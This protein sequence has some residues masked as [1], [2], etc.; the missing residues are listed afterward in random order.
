VKLKLIPILALATLMVAVP[1]STALAQGAPAVSSGTQEKAGFDPKRD[2][3]K[4]IADAIKLAKKQNKRILLDVG[5]EWWGWCKKLASFFRTDKDAAKVLK[6]K[7]IVVKVNYSQ[8]NENKEVLSMYPKIPG[9]PHFFVLDKD[10]K[11][12]HSQG[13]GELETGDHHDHDKMMAFLKK[14][15]G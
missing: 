13:T 8:E 6:E 7:F 5:G 4:D 15:G 12:L 10:G 11:F 9:Y 3:A 2:A 1:A 14:W